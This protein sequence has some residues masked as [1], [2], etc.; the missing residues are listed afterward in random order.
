MASE[1]DPVGDG[2]QAGRAAIG[3]AVRSGRLATSGLAVKVLAGGGGAALV[4]VLALLW[5]LAVLAVMAGGRVVVVGQLACGVSGAG[6]REI[7]AALVPIYQR[8]SARYHLGARGPAV[9]ASINRIESDFGRNMAT[10]SAGALGWMHFMPATWSAWGVDADGDGRRDPRNPH[11]AIHA[12]ARY[13]HAS[14]APGHWYRAVFAYNHADWYVQAVLR[15]ADAYQGACTLTGQEVG[16]VSLGHLDFTDTSGA[17]GGAEKFAKALARLGRRYGCLP[18]SEKRQRKYTT[19]GNVSDHWVGSKDAYAVDLDSASCTMTYPGGDAD[20]TARAIAAA[21][22]MPR[23]TGIVNLVRGAYRFQL[24]WQAAEHYDH[25]H[26][27]VHRVG[28]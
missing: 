1:R 22:G 20:H 28:G 23:H 24:L 26:V 19:S 14:G 10:S 16:R 7:P 5:F 17:W 3:W 9:L 6:R 15:R 12:A 8:A 11:D 2:R 4:L 27:G 25:V 21:L 18:T 13:L